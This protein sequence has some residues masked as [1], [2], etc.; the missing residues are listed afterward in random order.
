MAFERRRKSRVFFA[1]RYRWWQGRLFRRLVTPSPNAF[2]DFLDLGQEIPKI[3]DIFF[4][5]VVSLGVL[6]GE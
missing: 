2:A 6:V 1:T 3:F 4:D 5:A